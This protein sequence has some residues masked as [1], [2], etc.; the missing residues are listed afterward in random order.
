[1]KQIHIK[2]Y[3]E[4]IGVS[5]NDLSL[6]DFDYIGEYTA[7]KSRGQDSPLF[8]STGCFFRPNYERG[9]LIYSLITKFKLKSYLEIGFGRGY[10]AVCAAKAFYDIGS[11]GKVVT[12]D[13]SFDEKQLQIMSVVFPKE[14]L[15]KI[16]FKKGKSEDELPKLLT[17]PP[18]FADGKFTFNQ[19]KKFDLIYIDGDHRAEGV[20]K[21]W[22][23]VKDSWE[24][25]CLF[26]DYHLPTKKEADIECA[27]VI[28][29]I[30]H[31]NKELIVMDRRIFL[32]DRRYTDDQID[33]GQ[34]LLTN[35]SF[36]NNNW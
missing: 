4:S 6:G 1:M 22:E 3:L 30:D 36:A 9:L 35:K 19:G 23:L 15:E 7:K 2:D 25:F 20:K 5:L 29:K 31:P 17:A 28:D 33:Y 14:W 26:D 8:K 13:P 12:I 24:A 10:S 16:E 18:G 21:D 27:T 34:V 11:D 32:D